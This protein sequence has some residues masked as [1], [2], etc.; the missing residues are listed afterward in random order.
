MDAHL[1]REPS[2][3]TEPEGESEAAPAPVTPLEG[4]LGAKQR[5][6]IWIQIPTVFHLC[7]VR[8]VAYF[9][10][11]R[12]KYAEGRLKNIMCMPTTPGAHGYVGFLFE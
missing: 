1:V 10:F 3:V 8:T 4:G 7:T 6:S 2:V 11:V 9:T 5:H 12:F